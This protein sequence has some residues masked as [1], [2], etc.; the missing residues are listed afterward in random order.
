M[1]DRRTF[2][3]GAAVTAVA[4]TSVGTADAATPLSNGVGVASLG[5]TPVTLARAAGGW[6]LISDNGS[7]RITSGLENAG[8]VDLADD[9]TQLVAAGSLAGDPVAALWTSGDGV[10]WREA[11]RLH[12]T[13]TEFTATTGTLAL[14]AVVRHE[15]AP[16]VRVAVRRTASGWSTVPVRGL[17]D[18]LL[19]SALATTPDGFVCAAVDSTGTRVHTSADGVVWRELP[20]VDGVAVRGLASVSGVVRWFGNEIAGSTPLTGV[21]GGTSGPAAVPADAKALGVT[22]TRAAWLSGGRLLTT[23]I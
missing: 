1:L 5:G 3:L 2:V 8:L 16:E 23:A 4:A 15:R 18:G 10:T 9:G 21:V 7:V 6:S 13:R 19:A 22:G 14:G 12:G 11:R 20:R 17:A